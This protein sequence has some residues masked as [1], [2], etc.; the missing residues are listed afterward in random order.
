MDHAEADELRLLE[1]GNQPQHA[2]LL[3][4]FH[5]RLE[6]D[7]AEVIAGEV[8]L[9]QLHDRV[10]LAAGAR[11]RQARPASSARTAACRRRV[12]HHFDRQAAFEELRLVEVV[13][14]RLSRRVI[15]AS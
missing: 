14:R 9:P 12:R 8:V 4:P 10:G 3:A 2:R 6:P 5:L 13:Q 1:P 11:I 15:S 7:Q